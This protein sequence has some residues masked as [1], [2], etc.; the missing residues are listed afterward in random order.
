MVLLRR[1]SWWCPRT[2]RFRPFTASMIS[3]SAFVFRFDPTFWGD[4]VVLSGQLGPLCRWE[5][6]GPAPSMRI[7]VHAWLHEGYFYVRGGQGRG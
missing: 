5:T 6:S 4:A 3:L 2:H 1:A 7:N